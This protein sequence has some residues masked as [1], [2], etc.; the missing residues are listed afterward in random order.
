MNE[1]Y[2]THSG[3]D[4]ITNIQHGRIVVT[5]KPP[6]PESLFYRFLGKPLSDYLAFHVGPDHPSLLAMG[7]KELNTPLTGREIESDK[8]STFI[9]EF[10][11]DA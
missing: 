4:V 6:L 5:T 11:G 7:T 8:F 2:R 9:F 1:E 10:R 3:F